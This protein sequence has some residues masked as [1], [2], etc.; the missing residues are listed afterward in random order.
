MWLVVMFGLLAGIYLL[1]TSNT[2]VNV[3]VSLTFV[4]FGVLFVLFDR[5]LL[6]CYVVY[7]LFV[8]VC[9]VC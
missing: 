3:I 2:F 4:W 9:Y 6:L 8:W 7:C 1:S 5:L